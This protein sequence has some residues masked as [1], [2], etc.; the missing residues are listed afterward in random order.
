MA[1]IAMDAVAVLD[2]SAKLVAVT[3]TLAGEG[4]AGGAVKSPALLIV[5]QAAALHPAPC[6]AQDTAVFE[7]PATDAFNC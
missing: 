3:V 1:R 6:T 5:P 4:T 7:V 2:G